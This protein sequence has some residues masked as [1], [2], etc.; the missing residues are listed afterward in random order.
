MTDFSDC[1]YTLTLARD[2]FNA[3]QYVL[4]K[5]IEKMRTRK[6]WKG[7]VLGEVPVEDS[8]IKNIKAIHA[9][10]AEIETMTT[11]G[12]APIDM[13]RVSAAFARIRAALSEADHAINPKTTVC[14]E[15]V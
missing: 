4:G 7:G 14:L 8:D 13:A 5:G 15:E 1:V 2:E 9:R 6:T 11:S 10:L 3:L 12:Q